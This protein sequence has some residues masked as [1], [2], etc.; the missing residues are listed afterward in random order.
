VRGWV[1]RERE[2]EFKEL[3]LASMN[4]FICDRAAYRS[5]SNEAHLDKSALCT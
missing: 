3:G 5:S 4:G 2:G 1:L